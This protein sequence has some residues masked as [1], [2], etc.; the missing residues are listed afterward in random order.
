MP[1]YI[2]VAAITAFVVLDWAGGLLITAG[3]Y[4]LV[5]KWRQR[6]W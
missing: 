1:H 6:T 5:R 4:W 2:E 3:L